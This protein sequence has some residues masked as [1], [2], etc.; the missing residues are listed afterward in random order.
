[1]TDKPRAE[2]VW[3]RPEPVARPAPG[4]LSRERIVNAAIAIADAEGLSAVSLRKVAA[5]LDAGP[6]RLYGYMSTKEELLELMVDSV[7]GELVSAGPIRGEWRNVLRTLAER[8][9]DAAQAHPWFVDLLVGRPH[10]GPHALAYLESSL[11]SLAE[12]PGFEDIDFVIDA[13][14]TV[15]AYV[16]GALRSEAGELLAELESGQTKTEWQQTVW[17]YMQRM[18]ATGRFPTLAKVVRDAAHPS[19]ARVFEQR[20]EYVLDGIAA[21]LVR[22]AG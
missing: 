7:Y 17:P 5:A 20:L 1:M 9:R 14:G 3:E 2:L 22:T 16:I 12:A 6:M 10:L 13:V 15:N 11:A 4:P 19:L 21:R 18:L 8:T